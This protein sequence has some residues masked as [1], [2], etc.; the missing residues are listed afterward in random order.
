LVKRINLKIITISLLAVLLLSSFSL[1]FINIYKTFSTKQP[2]AVVIYYN[3]SDG[4]ISSDKYDEY[5]EYMIGSLSALQNFKTSVNNGFTFIGKTV[6]LTS[7]INCDGASIQI[8]SNSISDAL[9]LIRYYFAGTFDGKGYTI[10]NIT[11]S[12][13]PTWIS[14]YNLG[15]ER[16]N[17]GFFMN[18]SGTIKNLKLKNYQVTLEDGLTSQVYAGALVG[19]NIGTVQNCIVENITFR[20]NRLK[21]FVRVGSLVGE[22]EGAG[23]VDTCLVMGYYKIGGISDNISPVQDDGIEAAYFVGRYNEATNS[24]FY[25]TV[26][27]IEVTSETE[28][29]SE[30]DTGAFSADNHNYSDVESALSASSCSS[31]LTRNDTYQWYYGGPN[32]NSGWPIPRSFVRPINIVIHIEMDKF[33]LYINSEIKEPD[34]DGCVYVKIPSDAN[35][36][37]FDGSEN[38]TKYYETEFDLYNVKISVTPTSDCY[39]FEDW[40]FVLYKDNNTYPAAYNA[41]ATLNT[42]TIKFLG[43]PNTSQNEDSNNFEMSCLSN[44]NIEIQGNKITFSFEGKK[45]GETDY[46]SHYIT[47][48]VTSA[49]YITGAYYKIGDEVTEI[50]INKTSVSIHSHESVDIYIT[51]Q[52]KSYDVWFG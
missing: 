8:G 47:Y 14:D 18:N 13:N 17:H 21:M 9:Q 6:Y 35:L 22:N 40:E 33:D 12:F 45:S 44:V 51:V 48:E 41:R 23:K 38:N 26:E 39:F 27:E 19:Y 24:M 16:T 10:S 52:L 15:F 49:Y 20:S 4:V 5:D 1:L 50:D 31:V 43:V 36:N 7:N 29:P 32:Y 3:F 25:A 42:K 11:N 34:I 2:Q 30:W 46:T 28:S 37:V